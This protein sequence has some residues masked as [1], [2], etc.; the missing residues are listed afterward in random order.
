MGMNRYMCI[1][2]IHLVRFPK[3]TIFETVLAGFLLN[4]HVPQDLRFLQ[5]E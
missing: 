2:N 4:L 5:G 1:K 3:Q